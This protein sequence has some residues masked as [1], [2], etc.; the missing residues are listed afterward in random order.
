MNR[1]LVSPLLL[2]GLLATGA[3]AASAQTIATSVTADADP[4]AQAQA[5]ELNADFTLAADA[6]PEIDRNCLQQTGSRIVSRYNAKRSAR[7]TDKPAKGKRCVA[8]FGRVY[9]REDLD[10]TG[11]ID[12]ADALRKLDPSIH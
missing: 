4:A 6:E 7:A 3:F 9:S 10:R 2:A 1:R 5:A 8:A 12:I 11:E